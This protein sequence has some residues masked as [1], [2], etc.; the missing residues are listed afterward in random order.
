MQ[1]LA[2]ALEG[3]LGKPVTDATGLT[4]KY[5][6]TLTFSRDGCRA[7][8]LPSL[9]PPVALPLATSPE[10]EPPPDIFTTLQLQLGLKLEPKKGGGLETIVVID[11]AEKSPTAN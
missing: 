5:D 4:A 7:I 9:T 3:R 8:G 10:A 6:F 2:G 11:H 1:G